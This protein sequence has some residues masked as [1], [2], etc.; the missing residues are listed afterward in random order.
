MTTNWCC[1]ARV[2]SYPDETDVPP[3]ADVCALYAKHEGPHCSHVLWGHAGAPNVL[4]GRTWA[5]AHGK[6]ALECIA[7]RLIGIESEDMTQTER[8]IFN[9][10]QGLG[11]LTLSGEY[12]EVV[13]C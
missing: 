3:T 1:E 13:A 2:T 11:L 10:L 6:P 5:K 7:D 9:I 12:N 8:Q 4:T